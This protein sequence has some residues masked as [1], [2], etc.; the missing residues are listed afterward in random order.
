M[1]CLDEMATLLT[2][3]FSDKE[4]LKF[5]FAILCHDL[6]KAIATTIEE[7]GR[8]RSIGHEYKG[9]E[10]TK[11][12]LYR[13]TDEHDFIESILPLVEHHLKP[14]QFYAGKSKAT[15]IRRLATK[16]NIEAL[17]LV[18]RADFLGRTTKES[19]AG[20]YHAGD[21]LLER[22]KAL[23][24]EKKPLVPLLQGRDLIGLGLIPSP[25]FKAILDEVYGL[26]LEGKLG[27]R[28]EAL[29]YLNGKAD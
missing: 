5:L 3:S 21:W 19:L 14:S 1:M 17:V 2:P 24:V 26:Q 6:G 22:A 10:P 28:E 8:I 12:F 15:A 16:V 20:V 13:L 9:I 25:K 11:S 27:T 23:N 18:A 7:D 29:A 4:R